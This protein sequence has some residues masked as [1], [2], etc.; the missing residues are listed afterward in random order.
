MS[1]PPNIS[2]NKN[3]GIKKI[4]TKLKRSG[5]GNLEDI[6]GL[7]EFQRGGVRATASARLGWS[8]PQVINKYVEKNCC[9]KNSDMYIL[10]LFINF[11][12]FYSFTIIY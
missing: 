11:I 10:K 6:P 9:I 4:F 2:F 12:Y 5:S 3:K 8:E 7:G 1:G